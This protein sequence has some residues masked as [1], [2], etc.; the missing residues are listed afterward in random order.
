MLKNIIISIII[1]IIMF[2]IFLNIRNNNMR[3]LTLTLLFF[4]SVNLMNDNNY[5][6][7]LLLGLCGSI[8]EIIYIKYINNTWSYVKP[9]MFGIPFWLIILWALASLFIV[10]VYK[11]REL[12]S[13]QFIRT[14]FL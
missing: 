14:L 13:V 7:Y 8:T 2:A 12:L 6:L 11:A 5:I 10:N 9:D 1:F 4:I 3:T